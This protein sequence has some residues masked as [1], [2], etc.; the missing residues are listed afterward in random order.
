[1]LGELN[2][3]GVS[4]L[5]AVRYSADTV[6]ELAKW[7]KEEVKDAS[8]VARTVNTQTKE[9]RV[10]IAVSDFE[11]QLQKKQLKL[12]KN[13]AKFEVK[14]AASGLNIPVGGTDAK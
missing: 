13:K 14:L 10:T 7:G 3:T 5:K 4:T 1:M 12:A 9:V 2:R 8:D 11:L 6:A